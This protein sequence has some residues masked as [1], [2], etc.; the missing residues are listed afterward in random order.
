MSYF[1]ILV[2][3]VFHLL[4]EIYHLYYLRGFILREKNRRSCQVYL[5]LQKP[6]KTLISINFIEYVKYLI[7]RIQPCQ[8][9]F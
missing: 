9:I 5:F 8:G 1:L 3:L 7:Y 6:I 4:R 2:F